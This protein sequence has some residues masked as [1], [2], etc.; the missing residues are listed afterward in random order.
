MMTADGMMAETLRKPAM[1]LSYAFDPA[2]RPRQPAN[3][4]A[5]AGKSDGIWNE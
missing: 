5:I 3:E 2:C 1:M 4:S